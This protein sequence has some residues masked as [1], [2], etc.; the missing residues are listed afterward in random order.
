LLLVVVVGRRRLRLRLPVGCV[1]S[2]EIKKTEIKNRVH[3]HP[4]TF[5]GESSGVGCAVM[6]V[7]YGRGSLAASVVVVVVVEG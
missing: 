1:V 6:A 4:V 2:K 5:T 3:M 7:C